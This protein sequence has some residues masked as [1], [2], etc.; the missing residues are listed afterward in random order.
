MILLDKEFNNCIF[1]TYNYFD[2]IIIKFLKQIKFSCKII[3][4]KPYIIIRLHQNLKVA[5]PKK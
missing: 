2:Y 1:F 5:E 4:N 3:I